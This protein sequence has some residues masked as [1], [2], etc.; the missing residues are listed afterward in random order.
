MVP[1][2]IAKG[3]EQGLHHP[4]SCGTELDHILKAMNV[5]IIIK[6]L[7]GWVSTLTL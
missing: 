6:P 1:D 4:E 7:A 2:K 3:T 5:V